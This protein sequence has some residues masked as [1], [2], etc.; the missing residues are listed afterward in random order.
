MQDLV[1]VLTGPQTDEAS[2]H[3]AQLGLN[4]LRIVQKLLDHWISKLSNRD[5]LPVTSSTS[6]VAGQ[7]PF[8]ANF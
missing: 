5:F 2:G 4:S 3:A 7:K 6:M 1:V 8:P